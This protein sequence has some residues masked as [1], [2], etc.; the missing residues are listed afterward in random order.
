MKLPDIASKIKLPG[1]KKKKWILAGGVLVLIVGGLGIHSYS[2]A[3][4]AKEKMAAMSQVETTQVTRQDLVDSISVTGTIASADSRDVSAIASNVE[5]QTVNY[6]VG[7]YVNAGDTVVVLD[8]TDLEL[9]LTE[10]QNN[11][12]LSTYNENKSIE[13]ASESYE[14][15]VEDGTD[16]YSKAVK[17]EA[18]AKEDLQDAE[19][20]LSSAAEALKRQEERVSE[21]QASYDAQ[22]DVAKKAELETE[23]SAAKAEYTSRHQAYTAAK[24]AEEKASDAYETAAENLETATKQNDRNIS[25]AADSLEKAQMQKT[26]SN[27]SSDQ[28][29]ENYQEQIEA[30]TVTAPIS[31]VITAMNVEEGDTYLGEGKALFTIADEQNYIVSASVD[32]YDISSISADMTAAVIVEALGEDELAGKVSFV[33]PVATTSNTGS[34]SYSIEIA[35]DEPNSDL[36]IGMT[37]KASIVKEAVYDVLALIAP[38]FS[39]RLP[40]ENWMIY[41]R[42]RQKAVIHPAGKGWFLVE[43]VDERS[44]L[45]AEMSHEEAWYGEL[46][47][48]FFK[49]LTIEARVNQKL[50]TSLIPLKYRDFMK[51]FQNESLREDCEKCQ[52]KETKQEYEKQISQE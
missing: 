15:A 16:D 2:K 41:D 5:V 23:L 12:A 11:Q 26:Y 22:I 4:A 45:E 25:N 47:K 27:D 6:K 29:I 13:T 20:D 18:Q 8:S 9:K 28:S 33:S 3:K 40:L 34:S 30:C 32:E 42:R 21:L 14:Q 39:N 7:D 10:A 31:G 52:N 38:H 51:E 37:A 35:L 17:N 46:W 50:Q 43:E 1:R 48:C 19:G 36:R 49:T 24:E 44:V